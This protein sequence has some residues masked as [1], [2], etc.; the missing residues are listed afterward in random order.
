MGSYDATLVTVHES[1]NG[2]KS[3]EVRLGD[4]RGVHWRQPDHAPHELVHAFVSCTDFV[5]GQ[6]P[7]HCDG[8]APHQLL[9]CV[10]K[11]HAIE[12]TYNQLVRRASRVLPPVN[13]VVRMRQN[14]A[15]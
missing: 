5:H 10:L 13:G 15:S 2:W 3:A 11:K 4:I 9:I 1:W 14:C 6:I 12:D 8:S 7:H